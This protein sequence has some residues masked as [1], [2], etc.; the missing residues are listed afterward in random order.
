[1]Q[2]MSVYVVYLY[3]TYYIHAAVIARYSVHIITGT[4]DTC[5]IR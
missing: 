3:T 2:Y 5:C 1:M 4:E